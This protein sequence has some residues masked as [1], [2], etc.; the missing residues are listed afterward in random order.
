MACPGYVLF[1]R[2]ET[3]YSS[4][5][6]V[7]IKV[8]NQAFADYVDA[9]LSLTHINNKWVEHDLHDANSYSILEL[10]FLSERTLFPLYQ[11]AFWD[12]TTLLGRCTSWN[13]DHGFRVQVPKFITWVLI[14]GSPRSFIYRSGQSQQ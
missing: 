6:A 8:G 10:I 11:D 13:Q 9:H 14:V 1:E 2:S 7:H 3:L 12:F 4:L 5:I